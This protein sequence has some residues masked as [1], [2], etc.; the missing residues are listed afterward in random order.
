MVR[1]Y[2]LSRRHLK[3]IVNAPQTQ[4]FSFLDPEFAV[5]KSA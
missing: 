2:E 5:V 1:I 3:K 4:S